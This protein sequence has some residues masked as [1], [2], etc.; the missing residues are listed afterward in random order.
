M[1]TPKQTSEPEIARQQ[2]YEARWVGY[3]TGLCVGVWGI[4]LCTLWG[5]LFGWGTL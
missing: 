4:L 2:R 1:K 3:H 5:V